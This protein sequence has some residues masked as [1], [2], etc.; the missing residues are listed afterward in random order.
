MGYVHAIVTWQLPRFVKIDTH[1]ELEAISTGGECVTG[2]ASAACVCECGREDDGSK[3][4]GRCASWVHQTEMG[5]KGM[6]KIVS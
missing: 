2:Q 5:G 6:L 1:K 3:R 4:E